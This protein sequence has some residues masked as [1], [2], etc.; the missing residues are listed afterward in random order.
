MECR[1]PFMLSPFLAASFPPSF[2]AFFLPRLLPPLLHPSP[3]PER[4]P[5]SPAPPVGTAPSTTAPPPD[6]TARLRITLP[7]PRG[8]GIRGGR[9][10]KWPL[11]PPVSQHQALRR[12]VPPA[13]RRRARVGA[14]AV[15]A[16]PLTS[17]RKPA[18]PAA[19]RL[20]LRCEDIERPFCGGSAAAV[21]VSIVGGSRSRCVRPSKAGIANS[22]ILERSFR[23]AC[24]V[25]TD[26]IADCCG[27]MAL[28]LPPGRVC[29]GGVACCGTVAVVAVSPNDTAAAKATRSKGR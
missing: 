26:R 24:L 28:L 17:V 3:R 16:A 20:L 13:A 29:V 2:L 19:T 10:C 21:A 15:V 8:V 11:R 5:P 12:M 4:T 7:L 23:G 25:V 22:V 18:E 6:G 1:S 14:A 9:G 27:A